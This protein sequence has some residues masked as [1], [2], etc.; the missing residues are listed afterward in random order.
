VLKLKSWIFG[1]GALLS[2]GAAQG[3]VT[4][5]PFA[6]V[7]DWEIT[8]DDQQQCSM[9]QVFGSKVA[10]EVQLLGVTFDRQKGLALSWV[11]NKPGYL[12]SDGSINLHL[13]FLK[14][15]SSN[16]T[17]GS[18]AFSYRKV[19]RTYYFNH[20]FA[21]PTDIDR[22]LR[23]LSANEIISLN[24]GPTLMMALPLNAAD[25]VEKLRECTLTGKQAL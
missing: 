24:L 20:V 21:G 17:W 16:E 11:S 3:A 10:E 1:V 5:E 25:A 22:V 4:S 6:T 12:P 15:S 14:G 7:G 9:S 8:A 19:G 18:R 13:A 2:A 23:D